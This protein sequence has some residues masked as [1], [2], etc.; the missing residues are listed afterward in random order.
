MMI[1]I[2]VIILL[3]IISTIII[4]LWRLSWHIQ[5]N[6]QIPLW[7]FCASPMAEFW[8]SFQ[9]D[10]EFRHLESHLGYWEG[11]IF[12]FIT[13]DGQWHLSSLLRVE[14]SPLKCNSV[15]DHS[16]RRVDFCHTV[17][18]FS[19]HISP[20]LCLPSKYVHVTKGMITFYSHDAFVNSANDVQ[21][22]S[23]EGGIH[24]MKMS[25]FL[26]LSIVRV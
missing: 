22:S 15:R 4:L 3:I 17:S 1:V 21:F 14:Y 13:F 8:S 26:E 10:R 24:R 6:S 7:W 18:F 2:R 20:I 16:K 12:P 11:A 19:Q 5:V 25:C 23:I 9:S